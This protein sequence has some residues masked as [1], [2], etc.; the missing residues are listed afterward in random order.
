MGYSAENGD[1]IRETHE[2]TALV[3]AM[4]RKAQYSNDTAD[5]AV[6]QAKRRG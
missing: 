3:S 2:D 1:P 6:R 5:D 4:T